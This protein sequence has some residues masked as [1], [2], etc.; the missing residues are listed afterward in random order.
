MPS[1]WLYIDTNFP[2]FTG[3][4]TANEKI[5]TVQNYLFLLV[6]QLRY[7]LR[8]LDLANMNQTAVSRFENLLTEPIYAKI[9]DD[10][11]HILELATEAGKLSVRVSDSEG[12]ISALQQT[13]E[14]LT[15]AVKNQSG[16]ISTLKQT[17]ESIS[18]AVAKNTQDIAG[19]TESI[20]TLEQTA[21]SITTT[22]AKNTQDIEGNTESI[23]GNTQNIAK[24]TQSLTQVKQTFDG[25][26]LNI[27]QNGNV[28]TYSFKAGGVQIGNSL[29]QIELYSHD[30][31]LP[32]T[33]KDSAGN[34]LNA[35]GQNVLEHG[36]YSTW[37]SSYTGAVYSCASY[38][39]GSTWGGVLV[40]QGSVGK[41]GE[42]GL[43]VC[44][45]NNPHVFAGSESAA[46]AASAS[47]GVIAMQGAERKAVTIGSISG[48]P[49]GMSVSI[50]GNG[51]ENAYFT[52]SVTS[53]LTSGNGTLS[54]PVTV[55]GSQMT[56]YWSYSVAYKGTQGQKGEDGKDGK[57]GKDGSD[58]NVTFD[59]I[60]NAL[61]S[62][63][64]KLSSGTPTT[65]S[66]YELYSPIIEAAEI[67]ASKIYA[68]EGTGFAEMLATGLNVYTASG[69]KKVG[70]GYYSTGKTEY[71]YL[72]LG[73]GTGYA[74]SGTGVVQKLG[75]GVWVGDD[76][77]LAAGGLYPGGKSSAQDISGSYPN[78]VGIFCDFESDTIYKYIK[79]VPTPL[80]AATFL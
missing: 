50:G 4:E 45:N 65:V 28:T 22:V 6:E 76:S 18:T 70:M 41:M 38:D 75:A 25:L 30:G 53:A 2:T 26:T 63:F 5:E 17:A 52:V 10:E 64:V 32:P 27:V 15:T 23:E 9:A 24:N 1:N 59:N 7:T 48:M 77:I 55:N 74:S 36:W 37:D 80:G 19:N 72:V 21:E 34:Y 35:N 40:R 11:G 42:D 69:E 20:S 13:A 78:A 39:S 49:T 68:G 12:N 43:T 14:G 58:A 73:A 3:E 57:D 44:L 33:H 71:P 8:N 60:N 67:R 54:V 31:L 47:V 62:L 66:D 79:G 61:A 46:I 16:D 51:T 29:D 56:L